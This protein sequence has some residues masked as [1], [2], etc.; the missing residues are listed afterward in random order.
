MYE[1]IDFIAIQYVKLVVK[2]IFISDYFIYK[3]FS[4][5]KIIHTLEHINE[6]AKENLFC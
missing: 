1:I 6:V 4:D 3:E 2:V 5:V